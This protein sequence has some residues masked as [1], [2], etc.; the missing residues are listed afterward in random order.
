V[1]SVLLSR[2]QH[3]AASNEAERR[4]LAIYTSLTNGNGSFTRPK[5]ER[6]KGVP[7]QGWHR[8]GRCRKITVLYLGMN[9]NSMSTGSKPQFAENSSFG[10]VGPWRSR[11]VEVRSFSASTWRKSN[12]SCDQPY[13]RR[14]T[15][16]LGL[17]RHIPQINQISTQC[18]VMQPW[19]LSKIS[20]TRDQS[21]RWL[22][23]ASAG[24]HSSC[25]HYQCKAPI[26]RA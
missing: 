5:C 2:F 26:E 23:H 4:Y 8:F 10:C 15:R 20:T 22:F 21:E 17:R 13:L 16:G 1:L 3:C 24:Q 12:P 18:M 6:F 11:R 25:Q 7:L 19:A 9:S 14:H